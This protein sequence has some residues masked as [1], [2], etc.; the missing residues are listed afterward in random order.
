MM[1]FRFFCPVNT[2]T[3]RKEVVCMACKN[4]VI[5]SVSRKSKV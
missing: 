5:S 3:E 2:L 4:L 1:L